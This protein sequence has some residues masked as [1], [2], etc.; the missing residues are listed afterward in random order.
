M[1]G[2][3]THWHSAIQSVATPHLHVIARAAGQ[4]SP[5]FCIHASPN[6][7]AQGG[8]PELRAGSPGHKVPEDT[9]GFLLAFENPPMAPTGP[10][11]S[12]PPS[13]GSHAVEPAQEETKATISA[14]RQLLSPGWHLENSKGGGT[15]LLV[16]L[17]FSASV[18][19]PGDPTQLQRAECQQLPSSK[20]CF[21]AQQVNFKLALKRQRTQICTKADDTDGKML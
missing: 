8:Y 4:R 17:F 16:C 1:A 18:E 6:E 7:A 13:S 21:F 11:A 12:A 2:W 20:H 15:A 19:A 5:A 9:L 3:Q 10:P 14:K